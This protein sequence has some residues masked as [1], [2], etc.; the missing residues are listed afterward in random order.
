ML[1]PPPILPNLSLV[2]VLFPPPFMGIE[3]RVAKHFYDAYCGMGGNFM[4]KRNNKKVKFEIEFSRNLFNYFLGGKHPFLRWGLAHFLPTTPHFN[5]C[6]KIP[7]GTGSPWDAMRG[8]GLLP[9]PLYATANWIMSIYV[10]WPD[11]SILADGTK[12]TY[13]RN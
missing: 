1:F 6:P 13:R 4:W 3:G 11:Y 9:P 5:L 12:P 10:F 8:R 7:G 2:I